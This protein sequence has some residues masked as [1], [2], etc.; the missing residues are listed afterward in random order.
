MRVYPEK[1]RKGLISFFIIAT[2]LWALISF[3]QSRK[4]D[5]TMLFWIMV[6]SV[7]GYRTFEVY[8]NILIHPLDVLLILFFIWSLFTLKSSA[9]PGSLHLLVYIGLLQLILHKDSW[10]RNADIMEWKGFIMILPS[11]ILVNRVLRAGL[12]PLVKVI[13]T[14]IMAMFVSAILGAMEYYIPS[15]AAALPGFT[16]RTD[17]LEDWELNASQ[18]FIRGNY[19]FWGAPTIGHI[20][21]FAVPLFWLQEVQSE[22]GSKWKM[23]IIWFMIILGIYIT[24]NRANWVYLL[25]FGSIYSLVYK[26]I[27]GYFGRFVK[28]LLVTLFVIFLSIQLLPQSTFDRLITT[29]YALQGEANYAEDSSGYERQK[30]YEFALKSAKESVWGSGWGS[31]GWAHADILQ[32]TANLGWIA[33]LLFSLLMLGP[34]VKSVSTIIRLPEK[35]TRRKWLVVFGTIQLVIVLNFWRNGIY[36]LPQTG[37]YYF[38][39]WAIAFYLNKYSRKSW[40]SYLR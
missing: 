16:V 8:S 6:S 21:V 35:S 30:L 17:P 1:K 34:L 15:L 32:L 14:F 2:T 3:V 12:K 20:M 7:W 39:F 13:T 40:V 10:L 33:G 11:F 36:N 27:S 25:M 38:I 4:K 5:E 28:Y 9:I 19:S 22:I 26:P 29:F 31:V 23:S 18:S 24:G 37:I